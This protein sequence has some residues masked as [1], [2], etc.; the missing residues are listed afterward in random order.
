MLIHQDQNAASERNAQSFVPVFVLGVLGIL[1]LESIRVPKDRRH[2]LKRDS[3]L[4]KVPGGFLSIPGEHN[5]CIY[6]K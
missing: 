1:P 2:F 5:L 4:S 3:M 6:D